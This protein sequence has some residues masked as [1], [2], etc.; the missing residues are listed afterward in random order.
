MSGHWQ[1]YRDDVCDV[2]G[3]G[4]SGETTDREIGEDESYRLKPMNCPG[5][6][7]LFKAQSHSYRELPLRY[8]GFNPFHWNEISRALSASCLLEFEQMN[9]ISDWVSPEIL[10]VLLRL[11]MS[12]LQWLSYPHFS[13]VSSPMIWNGIHELT[14][15]KAVGDMKE[16]QRKFNYSSISY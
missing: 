8:A 14:E 4:S 6:C 7:L 15:K 16:E 1:N 11:G 10:F 5:H 12:M 2:R 3:R 9:A 13:K